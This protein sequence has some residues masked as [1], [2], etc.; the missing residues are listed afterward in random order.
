MFTGDIKRTR[1]I[2]KQVV[3]YS[4]RW[5]LD[6]VYLKDYHFQEILLYLD[7]GHIGMIILSQ[8]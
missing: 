7:D 6:L 5:I 1:N 4:S 2:G 8:V 3:K